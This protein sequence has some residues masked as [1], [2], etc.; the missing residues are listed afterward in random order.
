[1][2]G[3]IMRPLRALVLALALPLALLA[4]WFWLTE[5]SESFYM[6][7]LRQILGDFA[8]T[9]LEGRMGSDV[10]PSLVRLAIGY[11]LAVV[12][13]I[14]AGVAI[15]SNRLLRRTTEPALE[16]FRA[17]PPP[18]LVPVLILFAGIDDLMK[19]LVIATAAVWPVLLNTVEGVRSVDE[20]LTDTARVYGLSR[21]ARLRHVVLRAASPQIMAGARQALSI[22]IIVMVISEMFAA[23]NGVGFTVVQFQ[24]SFDI[25]QMWTGILLL[26]LLGFLLS[27]AFRLT[28]RRV[29]GWYFGLR[30]A[31]RGG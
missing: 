3:L 4:L 9:W 20:V 24:R 29:L 7:P 28:E 8:P 15:G 2:T 18:V 31:Q 22:A 30:N 12:L 14:A 17:L 27:L 23:T 16:F 13:G 26:G 10:V 25:S 21:R 6:P 1:M 11:T 5:D 19:V